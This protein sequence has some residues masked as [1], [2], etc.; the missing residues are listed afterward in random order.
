[1]NDPRMKHCHQ[2][3]PSLGPGSKIHLRSQV[4]GAGVCMADFHAYMGEGETACNGVSC[5]AAVTAL[6]ERSEGW[7]V[8]WPLVETDEEVMVCVCN[9]KYVHGGSRGIQGMPRSGRRQSRM[10]VPGS[11]ST[12]GLRHGP[13]EPC[14]FLFRRWVLP[15]NRRRGKQGSLSD[16]R[17]SKGRLSLINA[18]GKGT[19]HNI[20]PLASAHARLRPIASRFGGTE[21][22]AESTRQNQDR[23]PS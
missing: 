5:A 19:T 14:D 17:N 4:N 3:C 22:L 9:D 1:M 2:D 6:V 21:T 12:C 20:V 16:R 11:Q 8:D 7:L 10:Y 23:W 18:T 13:S 15:R